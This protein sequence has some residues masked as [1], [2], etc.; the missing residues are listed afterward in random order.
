M[1]LAGIAEIV[2]HRFGQGRS[3]RYR[4]AEFGRN[5]AGGAANRTVSGNTVG[6]QGHGVD[7]INRGIHRIAVILREIHLNRI[8][9]G[10][11]RV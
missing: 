6:G 8:L 1:P 7:L 3:R 5:R 4:R 9:E 11:A 10:L 2:L